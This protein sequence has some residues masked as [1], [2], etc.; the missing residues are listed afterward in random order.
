MANR[1][2]R[3]AIAAETLAILESGSYTL[4][5]GGIVDIR[6]KIDKA[7]ERTRHYTPAC[8]PEVFD[9]RDQILASRVKRETKVSVVNST[10]FC[11]ARELTRMGR[12]GGDFPFADT[13]CLN[14]ASAKS[15]GG[16]FISGAQAQEEC[17]ARASALY[18]CIEPVH[19][20]YE[21]NRACGNSL[22]T[23]HMIYSPV[24]PVFR[25]DSDQ[26]MDDPWLTSIVTA[27]AVNVGPLATHHPE[28]LESVPKIMIS[29]IEKVLSLAVVND[30]RSLILGAWGCGVFKNEP[31]QMASW[32]GQHL[33][34]TGTFYNVF[35]HVVFAVLDGTEEQKFYR[36][37]KKHFES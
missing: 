18:P 35:E 37:F 17:L 30:C 20:Y 7:I 12:D 34:A 6:D 24:V 33:G 14:F 5:D 22:Y 13:L 32:F 29:R 9:N 31:A 16:G 1:K 4:S 21:T 3:A 36:P 8:F 27:P 26:L 19:E 23:D 25:D 2:Q 28:L 11:A 15:P 10:T